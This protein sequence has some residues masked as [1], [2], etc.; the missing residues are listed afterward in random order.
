MIAR[1][2]EAYTAFSP[3]IDFLPI[4]PVLFFMLAF[5]WQSAVSFR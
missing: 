1:L 2:P 3:I 4:I 5:V